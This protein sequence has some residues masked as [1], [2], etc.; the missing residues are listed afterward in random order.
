MALPAFG[1]HGDA[2]RLVFD[3]LIVGHNSY[4]MISIRINGVEAV[5]ELDHSDA[6]VIPEVA[7]SQRIS[8]PGDFQAIAVYDAVQ[9]VNI[10]KADD[11]HGVEIFSRNDLAEPVAEDSYSALASAECFVVGLLIFIFS[12]AG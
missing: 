8:P 4:D 11:L 10:F 1:E 5:F 7:G 6:R 3:C 9:A 12:S 2:G